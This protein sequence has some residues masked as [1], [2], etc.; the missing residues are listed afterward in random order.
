MNDID[1]ADMDIA[2]MDIVD[3]ASADV[4]G[5]D[6]AGADVDITVVD[7]TV[8]VCTYNR[9]DMLNTAL[10]SLDKLRTNEHFR[11]EILVVDN[12]STDDTPKAIER[13]RNE[14]Q[15][16]VRS[17]VESR[18]GVCFARNRGIQEARGQWIAFF[19]DDQLADP[20]WLVQLL[21]IATKKDARVVGG[22]VVLQLPDSCQDNYQ[23]TY[24]KL[25]GLSGQRDEVFQY[26][27]RQA[28][29][30]GNLMVHESVF[31]DV[32]GFDTTLTEAGEDTELFM[33]IHSAGIEGW[34][35]PDAIVKHTIP[36]YRVS[37]EYLK[38]RSLRQGWCL[39]RNDAGRC[40]IAGVFV[41]LAARIV[42]SYLV[43]TLRVLWNKLLK[44]SD[45]LVQ[46][47]CR[48]WKTNGY[49]RSALRLLSPRWFSQQEFYAKLDFRAERE[50]FP[51]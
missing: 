8:V 49:F 40:G 45:P 41:I 18:Q 5:A 33:R 48:I 38:W 23:A 26:D 46:F 37:L 11:Y 44:Q 51:T 4:A 22:A 19:D 36:E 29:G 21:E 50:S 39:A 35:T 15:S 2:D 43:S 42:Q 28:P 9:A 16:P 31:D 3:V 24:G 12:A 6:V 47:R 17:V 14:L 7:I 30:A 27:P 13:A 20:A 34:Y 32:G 10:R 1:I 25:L